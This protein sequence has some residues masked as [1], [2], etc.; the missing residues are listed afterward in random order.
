MARIFRTLLVAAVN[1]IKE[2]LAFATKGCLQDTLVFPIIGYI[3]RSGKNF[4]NFSQNNYIKVPLY[5][6]ENSLEFV[7]HYITSPSSVSNAA[8]I[9]PSNT[10]DGLTLRQNGTTFYAWAGNSS[11]WNALNSFNTGVPIDVNEERWI[12]ITVNGTSISFF[13]STDGE[14]WTAANTGTLSAKINFTNGIGLGAGITDSYNNYS[15]GNGT[16]LLEDCYFQYD[17]TK[18]V[19]YLYPKQLDDTIKLN[20]GIASSN[21]DWSACQDN[22]YGQFTATGTIEQI[23]EINDEVVY[24]TAEPEQDNKEV[25]IKTGQMYY[26]YTNE[27]DSDDSVYT[28][29]N[30]IKG[31]DLIELPTLSENGVVGGD[32]YACEASNTYSSAFDAYKTF[33]KSTIGDVCWYSGRVSPCSLT[34]YTPAAIKLKSVF[35]MNEIQSP[36]SFKSCIIQ[37]SNDNTIWNDLYTIN[38]WPST[39]S[40]SETININS[41]TEYKYFRFYFTSDHGDGVAVQQIILYKKENPSI[42]YD[43][44]FTA[45]NPQP[46]FTV[47][48][49]G[50]QNL[51]NKGCTDLGNGIYQGSAGNIIQTDF[52]PDFAN[53]NTWEIT[54]KYTYNTGNSYATIL[55]Y[56]YYSG[57][58]YRDCSAPYI[59]TENSSTF[60]V[61]LPL[62]SQSWAIN[63]FNTGVDKTGTTWI[64]L[65]FTGTQYIFSYKKQENDP[66]TDVL[67]TASST[68]TYCTS[69]VGFLNLPYNM[70]NYA[71]LG[72]ID[73]KETSITIDGQTTT[74]YNTK[75]G[76]DIGNDLYE[77]NSDKDGIKDI[78]ANISTIDNTGIQ[79]VTINCPTV[80][81]KDIYYYGYTNTSDESIYITDSEPIT[82][83]TF[84]LQNAKIIGTI[85]NDN[86]VFSNFSR[87][88][89]IQL[90]NPRPLHSFDF[91]IKCKPGSGTSFGRV[92]Q[93][94]PDAQGIALNCTTSS[95]NCYISRR[96]NYGWDVLNNFVTG[97]TMSANTDIYVRITWNDTDGV[98]RFYQSDNGVDWETKNY[99]D[100]GKLAPYWVNNS[101]TIG[102]NT[103]G[104]NPW[105]GSVD[106]N[107]TKLTI[108]NIIYTYKK[109]QSISTLYENTGTT[110]FTPS[111]LDPQPTFTVQEI[112]LNGLIE[113][114]NLSNDNGIYSNFSTSNFLSASDFVPTTTT[115]WE[116]LIKFKLPD[117]VYT[118]GQCIV[119]IGNAAPGNEERYNIFIAINNASTNYYI[120]VSDASYNIIVN[121]EDAGIGF[122]PFVANQDV[123][124]RI[125]GTANSVSV[126]YSY[127]NGDNWTTYAEVSNSCALYSSAPCRFGYES[128]S[129]KSYFKGSINLA[130]SY[131]VLNGVRKNLYN[132]QQSIL[133]Y[134][135]TYERNY[136]TDSFQTITTNPAVIETNAIITQPNNDIFMTEGKFKRLNLTVPD[137]TTTFIQNNG[138]SL[139]NSDMPIYLQKDSGVGLLI[140][141]NNTILCRRS[142]TLERDLDL[143]YQIVKF[144]LNVD[145]ANIVFKVDN[146]E[147]PYPYIVYSGDK[148]TY[149]I[150]KEDYIDYS[151]SGTV[152]Y[153][154]KDGNEIDINIALIPSAGTVDTTDYTY[155]IDNE[156]NMII[157]GYVGT[158]ADTTTPNITEN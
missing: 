45:L 93:T 40:Y 18:L 156:G 133:V 157:T 6:Y 47:Q 61:F 2:F 106:M 96:S 113:N 108:D 84:N 85:N 75:S 127:D 141:D 151:G 55:G 71:S 148:Y 42:L 158:N 73:L 52:V 72:T 126:Y 65:K 21:Y 44:T 1:A 124:V 128:V 134:N 100:G 69:P 48:N 24:V 54:T 11:H 66:Y 120:K 77:R 87:G 90:I 76:I 138:I 25:Q 115:N 131:L 142:W 22:E 97:I 152:S 56:G 5:S 153:N 37:G 15:W 91:I 33:M 147:I 67:V 62:G 32:N 123:I 14:T 146:R 58:S 23:K 57:T 155:T 149:T 43:N 9:M 38:N 41:N 122:I 34:Y 29:D 137:S 104:Y 144:N 88:N 46:T 143:H 101:Q 17:D 89:Y 63:N 83:T 98:Y 132:L 27:N 114:G 19:P 3:T 125:V 103:D 16:I 50:I 68:K 4:T 10:A 49:E 78:I 135:N 30:P 12:K 51:I 81:Q 26:A 111:A 39:G 80:G 70:T 102:A 140:K 74:F 139:Q 13:Y 53:A 94:Q 59:G 145:N 82:S 7:I 121:P 130:E 95:V 109:Q 110:E 119:A 116:F 105:N 86:G 107:E 136:E 31:G 64:K 28:I 36:S 154:S 99:S 118:G 8:L 150:S 129:P 117:Q 79:S 20:D 35:I 60:R 112:G 92:I